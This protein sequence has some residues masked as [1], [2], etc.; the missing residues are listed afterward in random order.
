MLVGRAR[1]REAFLAVLLSL[2]FVIS[3][4]GVMDRLD[5]TVVKIKWEAT[6]RGH[7]VCHRVAAPK[8]LPVT[9]RHAGLSCDGYHC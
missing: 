7:W 4:A 2:G 6:F 9:T 5:R 1:H 3:P 8:M